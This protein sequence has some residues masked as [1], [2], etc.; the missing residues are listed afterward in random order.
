MPARRNILA[1]LLLSTFAAAVDKV[2][3]NW[4]NPT[5]TVSD[6]NHDEFCTVKKA[7]K[8]SKS[9]SCIVTT[10]DLNYTRDCQVGGKAGVSPLFS[11]HGSEPNGADGNFDGTTGE[12]YQ[13]P[14]KYGSML[15]VVQ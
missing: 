14:G 8:P 15:V 12:I 9:E 5:A 2:T 10:L 13:C 7:T 4:P 11:C 6:K 1:V 3:P